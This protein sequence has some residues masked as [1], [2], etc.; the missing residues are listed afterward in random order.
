MAGK[1]IADGR[2]VALK[3]RKIS[4]ATCRFWSYQVAHY[5]GEPVQ[6]AQYLDDAGTVVAQKVRTAEK[7]FRFLGN[8]NHVGLYGQWLWRADARIGCIVVEGELDAL[9]VS[10][11]H[12]DKRWPVVSVPNGASGAAAAVRESLEWLEQFSHV[13]F[14]L[15]NDEPG[16]AATE[17]CVQLLSPGKAYVAKLPDGCKDAGEALVAGKRKDIV[18]AYW[19]AKAYRPDGI[20]DANDIHLADLLET[21]A[22]G[23]STPFAELNAM[24]RGIRK[25][26]MTLFSAGTGVGKSTIVREI[27]YALAQNHGLKIG[28]VFLEES[29]KKTIQGYVAIHAGIP[30]GDLRADPNRLSEEQWEN[31]LTACVRGKM[32]FYN[33]FGS[34]ENDVLLAKLRY[35][36][37]GLGC[38]FLILDHISMVVSG[39]SG[40][41]EGERKDIDRLMTHLRQLI[42]QT[43]VGVLAIVHLKSPEHGRSH[44]EGGQVSLAHLRGSGSLRQI[45][46]AIIALE[47][48]Q[49]S[50]DSDTARLRVLKNREYGTTGLAGHVHYDVE[51]GRLQHADVS[52]AEDFFD[53]EASKDESD[54]PF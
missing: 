24:T 15:D 13:V 33:H 39:Q 23:Y 9:A 10:E 12:G 50:G 45:P 14:M 52:E 30:L 3:A 42:E 31:A 43:G 16:R 35:F 54:I 29:Y 19:D 47:R 26:E 38:D 7:D 36:A 17:E 49:Q 53:N 4:E 28:N 32:S 1:L 20:I 5:R 11:C 18:A 2:C 22:V 37:V 48:D 46:D 34:L 40:S 25:G 27:G 51:T 6:V 44:E 21:P 8:T 41:G